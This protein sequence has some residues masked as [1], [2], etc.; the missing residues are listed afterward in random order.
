MDAQSPRK[1]LNDWLNT[2][3][4]TL[5]QYEQR[6]RRAVQRLREQL[7]Q[8]PIYAKE[9]NDLRYLRACVGSRF[10]LWDEIRY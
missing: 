1:I 6:E 7:L 2:P 4:E 10:N 3:T 8:I 9:A 5:T